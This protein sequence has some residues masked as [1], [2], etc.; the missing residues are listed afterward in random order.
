VKPGTEIDDAYCQ[1]ELLMKKLPASK[2][3]SLMNF[4]A[5]SG[6]MHLVYSAGVAS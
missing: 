2:K 4:T 6:I 1:N 5:F 3:T